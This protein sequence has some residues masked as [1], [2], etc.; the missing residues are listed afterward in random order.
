M[1]ESLS[2]S[3]FSCS[4][5][6]SVCVDMAASRFQ[7]TWLSGQAGM[8]QT[9][10]VCVRL[11]ACACVCMHVRASVHTHMCNACCDV[12]R[13]VDWAITLKLTGAIVASV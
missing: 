9:L 13:D 12:E 6:C 11:R 7:F 3:S 2:A 4:G 5:V 10:H 8:C 1:T